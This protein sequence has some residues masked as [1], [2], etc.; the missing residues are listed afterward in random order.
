MVTL[1]CC[2]VRVV[3]QHDAG[4]VLYYIEACLFEEKVLVFRFN[5]GEIAQ[6]ELEEVWAAQTQS[7]DYWNLK[8]KMTSSRNLSFGVYAQFRSKDFELNHTHRV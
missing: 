7:D 3:R 5:C 8:V 2:C 6:V 1:S 4:A